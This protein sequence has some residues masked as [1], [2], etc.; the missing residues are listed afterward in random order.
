MT[1]GGLTFVP[2]SRAG[3]EYVLPLKPKGTRPS[4]KGPSTLGLWFCRGPACCLP[5]PRQARRSWKK[6]RPEEEDRADA[7]FPPLFTSLHLFF[8]F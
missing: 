8:F 1:W 2:L 6:H 5:T 4:A 7:W 3:R